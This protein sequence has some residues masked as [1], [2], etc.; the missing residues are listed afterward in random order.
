MGTQNFNAIGNIKVTM[1]YVKLIG[2]TKFECKGADE[3]SRH[4]V[5]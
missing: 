5:C 1:V 4:A 3:P 2:L